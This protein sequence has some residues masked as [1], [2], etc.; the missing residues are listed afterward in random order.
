MDSCDRPK[1][2]TSQE[3]MFRFRTL[4]FPVDGR[5][6]RA[7]ARHNMSH[8]VRQQ[9]PAGRLHAKPASAYGMTPVVERGPHA[10]AYA[11][12]PPLVCPTTGLVH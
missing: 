12:R 2:S 11:R 1:V 8:L 9:T 3:S 6:F 10:S 5:W 4:G 7:A